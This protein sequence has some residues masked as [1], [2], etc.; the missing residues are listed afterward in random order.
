MYKFIKYD[1]L[2]RKLKRAWTF[3][4]PQHS[5]MLLQKINNAT[6]L[7]YFLLIK[8]YDCVV[9]DVRLQLPSVYSANYQI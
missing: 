9:C 1:K 2:V 7:K 4:S 8:D 5:N 3:S 6:N